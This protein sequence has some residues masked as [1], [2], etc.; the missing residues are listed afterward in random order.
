MYGPSKRKFRKDFWD[1]LVGLKEICSVRW[2]LGGDFN[3]FRRVSEKF[4]SLT[5]T[6]S[7]REFYFLIGELDLVDPNLNNARFTW[8]NFR[9][10]PICCRLDRFLLS[11][12]W[13]EGYPCLRQEVDVR[14]VSDHSPLILDTSPPKWGPTPFRFENAWME[15]KH[16]GRDFENWWKEIPLEGWEG[17]KW[18]KNLQRIKTHLKKWNSEVFGDMRLIEVGLYS[19][20][21][22]L[23]RLETEENWNEEL[24]E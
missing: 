13:V 3:V 15:H 12:E 21:K 18:M 2:C 6:R 19:R 11:N 23:D 4:N 14:T 20:L 5:I 24:R 1:E 22:E 16:F 9:Q 17:Y 8:S 10:S 7:M